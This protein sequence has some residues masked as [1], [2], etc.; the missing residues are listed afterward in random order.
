MGGRM[1]EVCGCGILGLWQVY[2]CLGGCVSVYLIAV[3][4]C[5]QGEGM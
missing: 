4:V 3:S 2:A 5:G 1:W